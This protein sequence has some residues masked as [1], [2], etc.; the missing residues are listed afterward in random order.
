MLLKGYEG[1][2]DK[3][4]GNTCSRNFVINNNTA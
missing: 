3:K 4:K 2:K 1:T